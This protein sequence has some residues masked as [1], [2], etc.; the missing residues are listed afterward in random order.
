MFHGLYRRVVRRLHQATD[1]GSVRSEKHHRRRPQV[2]GP[3]TSARE[4]LLV[5]CVDRARNSGLTR[6]RRLV[7]RAVVRLGLVLVPSVLSRL[8]PPPG[9]CRSWTRPRV[10]QLLRSERCTK[11]RS[12]RSCGR[13]TR[14]ASSGH[15]SGSWSVSTTPKQRS[16]W[17]TSLRFRAS[18][19]RWKKKPDA[20]LP[21]M[22]NRCF[23]GDSAVL[24]GPAVQADDALRGRHWSRKKEQR[25]R[26]AKLGLQLP[27][28][29]A[30]RRRTSTACRN[31]KHFGERVSATSRLHPTRQTQCTATT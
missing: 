20:G 7:R 22:H 12:S 3:R 18:A 1:C 29:T 30:A 23:Q 21:A 13:I 10:W 8:I 31:G 9:C 17:T 26:L 15:C 24:S 14:P 25:C 5:A 2:D 19:R 6:G 11:Y 16:G 27:A 28:H 4:S